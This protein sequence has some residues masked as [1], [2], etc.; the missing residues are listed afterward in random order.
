VHDGRFTARLD[1]GAGIC[2]H[3]HHWLE[4]RLLSA[5]GD[6]SIFKIS[7]AAALD[8]GPEELVQSSGTDIAVL[9]YSVPSLADWNN[10][11]L[12]DL[13]VGEGG[14]G[15]P[16]LVRIYLNVGT[17]TEPVFDGY[18]LAQSNG[19]D[20]T[21]ASSG[22][23]GAF[24]RVVY[25]DA[26]SRKDLLVGQTD[27]LLNL[28]LNNGTDAAPQFDGGRF[29]QVGEPGH[30]VDIDVGNRATAVVSDW[31]SDGRK[32]LVV[33]DRAGLVTVFLNE[34]TDT[35]PDFRAGFFVE[36]FGE[37]LIVPS[38]LSSPTVADVTGDGNKDLVLGNT[39]GQ[40]LLY[41]NTG[42]DQAPAFEG[43]VSIT[44][45]GVPIDLLGTRSRPSLCD[46]NDSGQ[47]DVL[48]GSSDG[49]VRLYRNPGALFADSF[50][51]GDTS[52]WASTVG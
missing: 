51:T 16:G 33:G 44:S 10:D 36:S 6:R 50:E 4:L 14:D 45:E 31:N 37:D 24:P 38:Q 49:T 47:L 20:L 9:G 17:T 13:I 22:C 32:D 3:R 5:R 35:E 23:Q 21:V 52:A 8:L 43:W 46:W 15:F 7:L 28:F 1:F 27:G 42:T 18:T 25:W 48:V 19:S 39:D 34:G 40:L 26:D 2:V 29:L 41:E 30:K 12:P 11:T